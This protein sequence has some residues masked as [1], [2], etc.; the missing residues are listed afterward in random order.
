MGEYSTL[1]ISYFAS[2]FAGCWPS[3]S[4]GEAKVA[5]AP[6][7]KWTKAITDGRTSATV[8]PSGYTRDTIIC[9]GFAF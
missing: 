3:P 9:D 7:E 8:V 6:L 4:V 1:L 2:V 5:A